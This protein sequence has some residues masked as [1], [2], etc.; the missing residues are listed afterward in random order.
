M[1]FFSEPL[2]A[3]SLGSGPFSAKRFELDRIDP[4][5]WTSLRASVLRYPV[6]VHMFRI[7]RLLGATRRRQ[8]NRRTVEE[9]TAAFRRLAPADPVRYDFALTR[10]AL[11]VRPP[12]AEN[13]P[14]SCNFLTWLSRSSIFLSSVRE[15]AASRKPIET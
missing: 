10:L 7:G 8:A 12:D 13:A 4:G 15:G 14:R 5:G 9:I 3:V 1:P 11:A 2:D 6:D